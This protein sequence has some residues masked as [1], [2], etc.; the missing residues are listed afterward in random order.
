MMGGSLVGNQTR[1]EADDYGPRMVMDGTCCERYI[2]QLVMS[3][4]A[5]LEIMWC[6]LVN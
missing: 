6:S 2:H 1:W 3:L 4:K 5:T